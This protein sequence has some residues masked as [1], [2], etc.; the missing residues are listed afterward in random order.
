MAGRHDQG[1]HAGDRP[2]QRRDVAKPGVGSPTVVKPAHGRVDEPG[3]KYSSDEAAQLA[4]KAIGSPAGTTVEENYWQDD[5]HRVTLKVPTTATDTT[6]MTKTLRANGYKGGSKWKKS[7]VDRGVEY[8]VFK[9]KDT[10]TEVSFE[11]YVTGYQK[12]GTPGWKVNAYTRDDYS[13]A[14]RVRGETWPDEI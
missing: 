2:G 5:S 10:N 4:T 9:N 1:K 8:K 12:G 14:A 11:R 3:Y 7:P 6:K 13:D